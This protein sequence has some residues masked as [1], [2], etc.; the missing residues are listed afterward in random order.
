[1]IWESDMQTRILPS[2]LTIVILY[3]LAFAPAYASVNLAQDVKIELS[4]V[5]QIL[6]GETMV[7]SGRLS[8][9]VGDY[10]IALAWV[11]LQYYR[12]GDPYFTR[13]VTI[14]SSNPGGLFEDRFNTTSLLRIG[15]WFVN[16]SF[17]SQYGYQSTSTVESFTVVV[18][19]SLS[20]YISSHK[21]AL[22]RT[23]SFDGLLFACIPCVQDRVD[24]ILIRPD[25]NSVSMSLK[26]S[27]TG[28]PYPGGYYNGSFMP[29]VS[30]LWHIRAVWK[31]NE[32]TLPA[33]SQV[34]ELEVEAPRMESGNVV[35]CWIAVATVAACVSAFA[36]LL[37]RRH[38]SR[39]QGV[40]R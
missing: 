10:P 25:N 12:L 8:T 3:F 30:G 39:S 15:T 21:I 36:V 11:H 38:A 24:V 37:W 28:G 2:M 4:L 33:Y 34:E 40:P 35:T 9:V 26:L 32:V 19:P 20:L 1:M 29:D 5:H 22:N 14:I 23:V 6:R 17:P 7:I 31:G 16:A 13:E 18:Q 27:P